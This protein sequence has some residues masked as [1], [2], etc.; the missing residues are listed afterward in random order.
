V[1][2]FR[3]PYDVETA[4]AKIRN[5]PALDDFLGTRLFDGK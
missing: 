2:F 3:L 4:A 5:N 1:E